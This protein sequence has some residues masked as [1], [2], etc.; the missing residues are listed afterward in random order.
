MRIRSTR[1]SDINKDIS[2]GIE[3]DM[4]RVKVDKGKDRSI[5][6]II[7]KGIGKGIGRVRR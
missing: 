3:G 7:G 2:I 5:G 4:K 6:K 1:I